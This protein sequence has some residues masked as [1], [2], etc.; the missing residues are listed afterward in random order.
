[1]ISPSE[2]GGGAGPFSK[3]LAGVKLLADHTW[4]EIV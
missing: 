1:M 2:W 3:C 4:M